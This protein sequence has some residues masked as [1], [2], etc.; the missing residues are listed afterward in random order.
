MYRSAHS[1]SNVKK[2]SILVCYYF[3][4]LQV[5]EN[6]H[7]HD[8][9]FYIFFFINLVPSYEET[10]FSDH[11]LWSILQSSLHTYSYSNSNNPVTYFHWKILTL[12]GI[13]TQ[14]LPGTKPICYQLSYPGFDWSWEN[15]TSNKCMNELTMAMCGF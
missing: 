11:L 3:V 6:D 8:N 9:F 10:S 7:D 15:E 4:N 13:W 1:K 2:S 12:A 14:D 5:V